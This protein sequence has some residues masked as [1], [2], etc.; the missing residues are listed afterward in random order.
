MLSSFARSVGALR[1]VG[2]AKVLQPVGA[3]LRGPARCASTDQA[4]DDIDVDAVAYGFMGSKALFAAL[5][6]GVFDAISAGEGGT[7]T[8]EGLRASVGVDAP[9]LQ[10]L[11]TALTALRALRRDAAT[12]EYALSPNA[13]SF[14]V[15]SADHY[16]GDYLQY[17]VGSQFYGHMTALP[18]I[19]RGEAAPTYSSWFSDAAEAERYSL[20]QHNGSTATGRRLL[21]QI[22]AGAL[23]P[24]LAAAV[25]GGAAMLDV[26]GGTGA[27]SYVFAQE[28][29]DCTVL[30]LP[31]VAATGR[32]FAGG[33]APPDVADRVAFLDLDVTAPRWPVNDAAFDVVL[34]S[35][36]SGSVPE[37]VLVDVYSRAKAALK[38][39]GALVVHDFMVDDD[40]RGP[41]HA[42]LWALQHVTVNADGLGL[43]PA[44][45]RSRLEAAG[46]TAVDAHRDMI[47]G[48]T[49]V[50]V[51]HKEE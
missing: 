15:R 21:K 18:G 49:K 38:P 42:A 9:R 51:A 2:A 45:V 34:M 25:D 24:R 22:K 12:G 14:L 7:E 44:G 33:G 35:Y 46:F 39:G 27:F 6:L 8:L 13:A 43:S 28:G 10:T 48:M 17:Q 5:E 47:R 30:E 19:M 20:A 1:R 50:L 26:G 16:Y 40:L 41:P 4:Q 11:L 23:G 32:A 36:I 3:T 37:P 31:E 29:L